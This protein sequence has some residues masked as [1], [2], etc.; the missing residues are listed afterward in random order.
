LSCL[1]K[2]SQCASARPLCARFAPLVRVL[3]CTNC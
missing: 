3:A 2:L 1:T